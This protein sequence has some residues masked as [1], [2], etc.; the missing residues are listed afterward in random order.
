MA[1]P[2]F[3]DVTL[4]MPL[5][6]D[7]SDIKGNVITENGDPQIDIVQ[8]DPFG[9]NIGVASLDG[10]GDF[11]TT[12]YNQ[13][14]F[15]WNLTQ[16]T[17]ESWV[18]ASSW[19]DWSSADQPCLIGNK[20]SSSAINYWSFGT[21]SVGNLV[22]YYYNGSPQTII[23]SATLSV[24]SWHHIAMTH[25]SVTNEIKLFADGLLLITSAVSGTP[26]FS[27]TPPLTIGSL[28]NTSLTGYISN[29]RITNGQMRY[30]GSTYTVPTTPFPT[31]GSVGISSYL[32][33][34]YEDVGLVAS[35]LTAQ[36]S[37]QIGSYLQ[38]QY[39]DVG[40]IKSFLSCY[41]NDALLL[42]SYLTANYDDAKS[43]ISELEAQYTLT[44]DI[45]SS[46]E[47]VYSLLKDS[48]IS[49]L[50]A[51]Y[52][53][54]NLNS[55][56]SMLLALYN[57]DPDS[58]VV[59]QTETMKLNGEYVPFAYIN[60][61]KDISRSVIIAEVKLINEDDFNKSD[62][63][64]V[65]EINLNGTI[66]NF[67]VYEKNDQSSISADSYILGLASPAIQLDFPYANKVDDG[68]E[69]TTA[70][71]TCDRLAQLEGFTV[72]EWNVPAD[73]LLDSSKIDFSTLSP[74][75]AMRTIVSPIKGVIQSKNNGDIVVNRG[76][77]VNSDK[78]DDTVTDIFFTTGENFTN[79]DRTHVKKKGYN[80]YAVSNTS[81]IDKNYTVETERISDFETIVK[82]Y[83]NPWQDDTVFLSTS[84]V[85]NIVGIERLTDDYEEYHCELVNIE[86]G[87]G[88]IN[89]G[90]YVLL[91]YDYETSRDLG[92]VSI[93]ES[94]N[95][96]TAITGES[97][98]LIKYY[99]RVRRWRVTH[100]GSLTVQFI[101]EKA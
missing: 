79:T 52:N 83:Q 41:Y 18:Y 101:L 75:E 23:S 89:Y 97:T 45:K 61:E 100:T 54:D 27:N 90:G 12:P 4:L 16:Y 39:S 32:Q 34:D 92:T 91:D 38:V 68:F 25:D 2:Y 42:S 67:V 29:I 95:V 19:A 87:Y 44:T 40:L 35:F 30:D 63:L 72:S 37:L 55:V 98:V 96:T 33:A 28:N 56:K 51:L 10:V 47:A 11:L 1:D 36:Y 77:K 64:D 9:G 17:I 85:D 69:I 7:F 24:D 46:L 70:S 14:D 99:A 74:I 58:F 15:N 53:L 82:A 13:T 26:Q 6:S 78:L 59:S 60:L 22:F 66:Y 84:E 43:L 81:L 50:Q 80:R 5:S 62:F 93:D 48:N 21:N 71:D 31:T 49:S 3:N 8:P 86:E 57:I 76:K 65:V 88:N 73:G 20:E 94:K